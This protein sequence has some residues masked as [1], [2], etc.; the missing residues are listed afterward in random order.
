VNERRPARTGAAAHTEVHVRPRDITGRVLGKPLRSPYAPG[1]GSPRARWLWL[2]P[3]AWLL[4]MGVVSDHSL[5]R[6]ARLRHELSTA[7]ADLRQLHDQTSG[8]DARLHDPAERREH[9]EA[10]LRARGMA[11]PGE[12]IYRLG[13]GNPDSA[14]ST[15]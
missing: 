3:I 11:R 8:L 13:N 15:R 12:I 9:A 1:G 6:I 10:A 4:W 14:H 2:L 7:Q 5:W